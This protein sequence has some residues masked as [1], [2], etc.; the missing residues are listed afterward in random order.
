MNAA[1]FAAALQGLL[2]VGDRQ[3]RIRAEP[4][5]SPG[6]GDSVYVDFVNLP[7]GVGG[8]GGGAEAQNNR[9]QFYVR[10]FGANGAAASKVKVEMATSALYSGAGAPSRETRVSMRAKSGSPGAVAKHLADFLNRVA[11]EVAP[12]FTHTNV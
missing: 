6:H 7:Q 8:A 11:A 9:A 3:V 5:W 10:G 12:R 1:E 2:S 4:S